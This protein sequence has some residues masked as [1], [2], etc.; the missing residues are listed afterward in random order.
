MCFFDVNGYNELMPTLR[1]AE[2]R[3]VADFRRFLRRNLSGAETLPNLISDY[4][5]P[6]VIAPVVQVVL[7]LGD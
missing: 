7:A 3:L 1:K 2:R 5:A 6:R 4:V